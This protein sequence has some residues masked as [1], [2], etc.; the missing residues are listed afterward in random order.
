M[1]ANAPTRPA[2]LPAGLLAAEFAT[3]ESAVQIVDAG[4]PR[5][6]CLPCAR[7]SL[8]SERTAA[9]LSASA[10]IKARIDW[11]IPACIMAIC[12]AGISVFSEIPETGGRPLD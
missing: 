1:T 3:G 6:T 8:I 2:L 11:G 4:R 9:S 12:L 5:G 7:E 10:F